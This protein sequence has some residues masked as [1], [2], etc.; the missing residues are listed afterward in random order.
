LKK[1][2]GLVLIGVCVGLEVRQSPPEFITDVGS[3]VQIFC[4]HEKTDYR[5]MLWY[6]QIPGDTAM[7]L[8]GFL[9]FKAV[10]FEDQNKDHFNI[11]GDLSGT[12]AKNSSLIV[13]AAQQEHSAMYY[14]AATEAQ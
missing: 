8:I 7:K 10:T 3:K 6:Q 12:T 2:K 1:K 5:M 11:M 14:C 4:T 13:K 9:Y